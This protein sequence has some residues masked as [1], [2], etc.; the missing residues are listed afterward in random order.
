MTKRTTEEITSFDP[1]AWLVKLRTPDSVKKW[2]QTEQDYLVDYLPVKLQA[3]G[4]G[5]KAVADQVRRMG[6]VLELIPNDLER[7]LFCDEIGKSW[8]AFKKNYKLKKREDTELPKLEKL[9]SEDRSEFFDFGF[10]EQDGCY[11]TYDRSKIVR[12]CNFTVQILF[13]V[14]SEN[15]PKYVCL[16]KNCF[17]RQRI[18]AIT[19]DDFTTVGTFRKVIGRLGNFVFEGTDLHLN[20]I[21]LKLFH[22]VREAEEPRFMGYNPAGN[23]YTWA[24]GLYYDKA[25]YKCD[26]YGIV[27][28]R[29]P[30]PSMDEFKALPPECQVVMDNET[31]VLPNPEKF[32]EQNSEDTV[33]KYIEQKKCWHLSFYFLPFST[34]LKVTAHDDDDFEFERKFKYTPAAPG[35]TFLSWAELM[36]KTYGDNGCVA[37]AYYAMS[38]FRDIVYKGNNSYIPLLG[39]FGPKG[40]GKS[41]CARSLNKMFGEGLPDGVNLES[42]STATGIRRY[43]SSMQNAILWLNEYKNSLHDSVLAMIKGISDG[44][45]KLT[46]RNT[47][48]N[49]TRSYT[50]RCTV[51]YCGQ[52]LPTK[53]PAILSRTILCEFENKERDRA[54]LD[55]LVAWENTGTTSAITCDLLSHRHQVK[56]LYGKIEPLM[57]KR[58][59]RLSKEKL[60]E[61][62]DDRLILNMTS[63][64]TVVTILANPQHEIEVEE[65]EDAQF[66]ALCNAPE[67]SYAVKFGFTIAKL[68]EVLIDRLQIQVSVQHTS[69]DVEQYFNVVMGLVQQNK[70]IDN[71]HYKIMKD[72]AGRRLYLRVSP[73]H[74]MYRKEAGQ[75]GMAVMDIG[76]IR[77]YLRKHKAFVEDK[78]KGVEIDSTKT[79]AMVFDY[80]LLTSY[81]IEFRGKEHEP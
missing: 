35:E 61:V 10:W 69:D 9:K 11:Q 34:K 46:G 59:R 16:F 21:K 8:P 50:P 62:P 72:P 40:S 73:I 2:L 63:I 41:T 27:E 5:P 42:G 56:Q 32:L 47:G 80:D 51:V 79:S 38:I 17:G 14:R 15:E 36:Q 76:T 26:R 30:V 3:I 28:L 81:G 77:S 37:V 53:D 20:K 13:F 31:H 64:L 7:G 33:A 54:S 23:F 22:G 68:T 78:T 4:K 60:G 44:S 45:G 29:H 52:D 74:T 12:I 39:F 70:V 75:A 65:N 49:E 66:E 58:L 6:E 43:M 67:S 25:F 18:T 71:V 19:T 57:T 48:G 1:E 55:K 24:N